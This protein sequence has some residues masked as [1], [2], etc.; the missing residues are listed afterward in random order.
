[1]DPMTAIVATL[2][3]YLCGSVSFPHLMTHW[4]APKQALTEVEVPIPGSAEGVKATVYGAYTASLVLGP[5]FGILISLLD[6]A[7]VALPTLAFRLYAPDQA[8]YLLAS[9]AGLVGHVWP[10]YYKFKG[11]RGFT[12]I[13]GGFL[14]VDPLG[15]PVTILVGM[16]LGMVVLRNMYAAYSLWLPLMI[17]WMWLRTHDLAQVLWAVA[18]NLIFFVATIPEIQSF[19]RMRREGTQE[20]YDQAHINVHPMWRTMARLTE[21]LR[22]TGK[23]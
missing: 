3:G 18:L 1:L 11:G 21:R 22:L 16:L 15:V 4:L 6:M 20:A 17:P 13:I 12:A 23:R 19:A 9:V 14:A 10:L 2:V 8:Y 7:K 5:K